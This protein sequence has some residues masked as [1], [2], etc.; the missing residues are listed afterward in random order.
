MFYCI[1]FALSL[2]KDESSTTQ[3]VTNVTSNHKKVKK[4]WKSIHYWKCLLS[5][6]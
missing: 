5:K 1:R 2:C 4:E 6:T 3:T